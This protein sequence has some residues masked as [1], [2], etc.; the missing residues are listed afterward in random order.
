MD[1]SLRSA[2]RRIKKIQEHLEKFPPNLDFLEKVIN[3]MDEN[4][5]IPLIILPE[6]YPGFEKKRYLSI[7]IEEI[8]YLYEGQLEMETFYFE[9]KIIPIAAPGL[10]YRPDPNK[11]IENRVLSHRL[12]SVE[13]FLSTI[14][15]KLLREK[16]FPYGIFIGSSNFSFNLKSNK[17]FQELFQQDFRTEVYYLDDG[18]SLLIFNGKAR[19][20]F[21]KKEIPKDSFILALTEFVTG[22]KLKASSFPK[23]NLP[24]K[25]IYSPLGK[26]IPPQRKITP[27]NFNQIRK[28]GMNELK[29]L[30]V[31]REDLMT[32]EKITDDDEKK[33]VLSSIEKKDKFS[34]PLIQKGD[35]L[36]PIK[37]K[38][39]SNVAI[40]CEEISEYELFVPKKD[41]AII[42]L[43]PEKFSFR[44]MERLG[45]LLMAEFRSS[46]SDKF[47]SINDLREILL[48]L[49]LF[50]D[51]ERI[52]KEADSENFLEKGR[53]LIR[54]KILKYLNSKKQIPYEKI[55]YLMEEEE[56]C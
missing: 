30:F 33:L 36:I 53:K 48:E 50:E 17:S 34:S 25:V 14:L 43:D 22:K 15:F 40:I 1:A 46:S 49:F 45:K 8:P 19:R 23:E 32:G 12:F 7:N 3:I 44:E 41:I 28:V 37:R 52:L 24:F 55:Y 2:L 39:T 38:G 11:K 42:R 16:E 18:K 47:L 13:I 5:K 51:L 56:Q 20:G 9:E 26:K 31:V 54:R 27:S 10:L 4:G 29:S 35:I 6:L 21:P